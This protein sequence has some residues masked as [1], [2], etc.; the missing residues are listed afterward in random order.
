MMQTMINTGQA[1]RK[2]IAL[3]AE[4]AI[5]HKLKPAGTLTYNTPAGIVRP[6]VYTK[7]SDAGSVKRN[8]RHS[9]SF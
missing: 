2:G 9:V 1:L 8:G 6:G 7:G 3:D 5:R 4:D